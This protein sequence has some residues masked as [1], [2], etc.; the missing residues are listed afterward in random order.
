MSQAR[1]DWHDAICEQFASVL[2]AESLF[3][4]RALDPKR[5]S[6]SRGKKIIFREARPANINI[7]LRRDGLCCC[8]LLM[9]SNAFE[10]KKP[11]ECAIADV[12]VS[13]RQEMPPFIVLSRVDD[14][15][16][17]KVRVTIRV[18]TTTETLPD[19]CHTKRAQRHVPELSKRSDPPRFCH[20]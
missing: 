2:K 7:D 16:K 12:F 1:I 6:S 14:D 10:I 11:A 8:A 15:D 4:W 18:S 3:V 19:E 5:N 17:K 20:R 9:T 13:H